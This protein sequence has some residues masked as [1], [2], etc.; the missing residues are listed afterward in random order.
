[1]TTATSELLRLRPDYSVIQ[2]TEPYN[3]C[4]LEKLAKSWVSGAGST[5]VCGICDN[6]MKG[7]RLKSLTI[8]K[9][10]EHLHSIVKTVDAPVLDLVPQ[11]VFFLKRMYNQ[12]K[13]KRVTKNHDLPFEC[14]QT[15][16]Y[17]HYLSLSPGKWYDPETVILRKVAEGAI[18]IFAIRNKEFKD[19]KE[20]T[21]ADYEAQP[22]WWREE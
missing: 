9:G 3:L 8:T 16:D 22:T 12:S 19:S 14:L 21:L 18:A 20:A 1:M 5:L 7:V 4:C 10:T 15:T 6:R 2:S 13:I 17:G 11:G